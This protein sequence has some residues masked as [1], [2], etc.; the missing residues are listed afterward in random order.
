MTTK[1]LAPSFLQFSGSFDD[2]FD[3]I[4]EKL[5]N[6]TPKEDQT[7]FW[8]AKNLKQAQEITTNL[9][10]EALMSAFFSK[11]KSASVV[12]FRE[13]LDDDA[14][15]FDFTFDNLIGLRP[16]RPCFE[17][18]GA[19]GLFYCTENNSE[20]LSPKDIGKHKVLKSHLTKEECRDVRDLI[21]SIEKIEA[22]LGT[23][24][25]PVAAYIQH[26]KKGKKDQSPMK[27]KYPNFYPLLE[28]RLLVGACDILDTENQEK[29]SQQKKK[30]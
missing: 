3:E 22:S 11:H 23:T 28:K 12:R 13:G 7:I 8:G 27:E 18:C 19:E 10:F 9:L 30:M 14:G 21:Q 24:I 5:K 29:T 26:V 16:G 15:F 20:E 4:A 6:E 2:L 1:T 25:A 17:Y